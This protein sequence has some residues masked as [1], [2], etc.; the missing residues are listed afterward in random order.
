MNG[1]IM[2]DTA[3]LFSDLELDAL[4]EIMNIGFGQAAAD[5]AE[6]LNLRVTLSVPYINVFRP[7]DVLRFI[8]SQIPQSADMGMV[9]QF[10][11]GNFSGASFLVIPEGEGISLFNLFDQEGIQEE[12]LPD[13]DLL[14]RESLLEIGNII[15]GACV[16]KIAEMLKDAVHYTP[17]R[18]YAQ[19]L[20]P[21]ALD[22]IFESRESLA[23]LFKTVFSFND[24]DVSGYLFLVSRYDVM[25][26]LKRSIERY[27]ADY[28]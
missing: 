7:D 21:V 23:I 11:I 19:E 10:F 25:Q 24:S 1:V 8:H 27:L 17:P 16:G 9:T 26:W 28:A 2:P 22:S 5:L 15:I 20:I 6:M 18:Y 4:Q 12:S 3:H 13:I 14:H